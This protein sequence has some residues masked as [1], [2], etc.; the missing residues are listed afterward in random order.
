MKRFLLPILLISLLAFA[1]CD[2][3]I[4]GEE[5]IP[6]ENW[7][8]YD[9]VFAGASPD[10]AGDLMYFKLDIDENNIV[11]G[12]T[13]GVFYSPVTGLLTDEVIELDIV[14]H[15]H[16]CNETAFGMFIGEFSAD[17]LTGELY[18]E[19]CEILEYTY[20]GKRVGGGE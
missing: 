3:H 13:L 8:Q 17:D 9:Y 16:R 2:W 5:E 10:P 14:F 20:S 6:G 19:A 11:S 18:L 15:D 4:F 1:A 7:D 12:E